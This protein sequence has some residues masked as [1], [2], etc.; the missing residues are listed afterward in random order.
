MCSSF[1]TDWFVNSKVTGGGHKHKQHGDGV[2]PLRK[3]AKKYKD[4]K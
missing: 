2:R 1:E 4:I 3:Y